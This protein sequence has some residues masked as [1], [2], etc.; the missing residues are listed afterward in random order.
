[1]GSAP[2]SSPE[3]QFFEEHNIMKWVIDDQDRSDIPGLGP[4]KLGIS[5]PSSITST[6]TNVSSHSSSSQVVSSSAT[7]TKPSQQY[8]IIK[9]KTELASFIE[10]FK[11]EDEDL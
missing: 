1:M 10:K 8:V 2:K 7:S 5:C 3:K 9:P 4:G 6:A 11:V